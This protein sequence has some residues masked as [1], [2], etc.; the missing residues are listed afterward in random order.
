[1]SHPPPIVARLEAEVRRRQRRSRAQRHG[2]VSSE[3]SA[4]HASLQAV[5]DRGLARGPRFCEWGSGLGAVCGV[6][7]SLAYRAHGIEIREDFVI[8]SRDLVSRLGLEATFAHG[9]FL[10]PGDEDLVVGCPHTAFQVSDDPYR[11][12]GLTPREY[13]VVYAYPWPGEERM[14]DGLFARHAS[15][16]TLLLTYH[17][18]SGVLVQRL[19]AVGEELETVSWLGTPTPP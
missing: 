4:V 3:L 16:G 7:A 8:E 15:P 10:L 14:H 9:S 6:A 18:P 12:L 19:D 17:G 1:V 13:D 5:R 11:A 2:F